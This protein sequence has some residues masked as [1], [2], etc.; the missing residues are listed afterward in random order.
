MRALLLVWGL[1][2]TLAAQTMTP[3]INLGTLS[4]TQ[5]LI[6]HKETGRGGFR[7]YELTLQAGTNEWRV[8]HGRGLVRVEDLAGLPDGPITMS[9]RACYVDGMESGVTNLWRFELRKGTPAAVGVTMTTLSRTNSMLRWR[10]STNE[11]RARAARWT[12]A[13]PLTPVNSSPA[14]L[15]PV[16]PGGVNITR[17]MGIV[18]AQSTPIPLPGGSP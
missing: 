4:P 13:G 6:L 3:V 7:C 16:I 17:E 1:A 15:Y 9:V 12:P 14:V 8:R 11:G 2:I 10:G 5:G 18:P